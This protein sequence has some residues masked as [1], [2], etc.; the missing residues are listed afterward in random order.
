MLLT[1]DPIYSS[2]GL[3]ECQVPSRRIKGPKYGR[4][5]MAIEPHIAEI[6]IRTRRVPNLYRHEEIT[7]KYREKTAKLDAAGFI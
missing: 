2:D 7:R 6:K 1:L 3:V 4:I 5:D